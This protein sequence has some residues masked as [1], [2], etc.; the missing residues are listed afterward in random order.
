M[1]R[2]L[3]AL[4]F[5]AALL[6]QPSHQAAD[7]ASVAAKVGRAKVVGDTQIVSVWFAPPLLSSFAEIGGATKAQ[8]DEAANQFAVLKGYQLFMVRA[9]GIDAQLQS[10][11]WELPKLQDAVKLKAGAA[12]IAPLKDIPEPLRPL[13]VAIKKGMATKESADLHFQLLVFP[14]NDAQGKRVL[15]LD[16]KGRFEMLVAVEGQSAPVSL[17]WETPVEP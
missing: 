12:T 9:A 10:H 15:N 8:V 17:E 14:E 2:A 3:A 4:M 11:E 1:R 6:A 16:Q 7:Q 13:L 5:P